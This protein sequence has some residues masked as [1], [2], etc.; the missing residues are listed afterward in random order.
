M[1]TAM[2]RH[3][4]TRKQIK[5]LEHD[6]GMGEE[7]WV[8]VLRPTEKELACGDVGDGAMMDWKHVV[9]YIESHLEL[10]VQKEA[11]NGG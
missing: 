7:G 3:P 1:N 2:W 11:V 6:W 4:I 10:N 5:T 9:Q 8:T